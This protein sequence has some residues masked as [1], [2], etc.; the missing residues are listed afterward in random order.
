MEKLALVQHGQD[1]DAVIKEY[2]DS[3]ELIA[4]F[5]IGPAEARATVMLL[6]KTSPAFTEGLRTMVKKY[7]FS[8][9]GRSGVIT[10]GALACDC[11]ALNFEELGTNK[12]WAS[13][14][15][16]HEAV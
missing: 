11:L 9:D 14:V 8:H 12:Y 2:N 15:R 6:N 3:S 5:G 4:T 10:H 16:T 13:N 1:S 7:G